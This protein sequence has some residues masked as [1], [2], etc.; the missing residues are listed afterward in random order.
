VDQPRVL[1]HFLEYYIA[2]RFLKSPTSFLIERLFVKFSEVLSYVG[3]LFTTVLG[4]FI[5]VSKY[6]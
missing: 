2:F 1:N 4:L 6:N 5:I 3:G